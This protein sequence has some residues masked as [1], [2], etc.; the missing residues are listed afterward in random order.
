MNLFFLLEGTRF[1]EHPTHAGTSPTFHFT[2]AK[3]KTKQS[4]TKTEEKSK[5]KQSKKI[6]E[7]TSK[8]GVN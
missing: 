2:T 3:A 4:N 7:S 5:Q 8:T 6:K 1:R